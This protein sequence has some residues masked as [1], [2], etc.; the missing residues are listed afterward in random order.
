VI[1]LSVAGI[2]LAWIVVG[3]GFVVWRRRRAR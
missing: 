2:P 3:G 1:G